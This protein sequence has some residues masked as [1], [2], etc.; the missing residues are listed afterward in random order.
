M[1]NRFI[2]F[3]IVVSLFSLLAISGCASSGS[4][5]KRVDIRDPITLAKD[6]VLVFGKIVLTRNEFPLSYPW[7]QSERTLQISEVGSTNRM[8]APTEKDGCFYWILPRGI[9]IIQEIPLP[10]SYVTGFTLLERSL[11]PYISFEILFPSHAFYLGTLRIDVTCD[12]DLCTLNRLEVTDEFNTMEWAIAVTYP[13][14]PSSGE[15]KLLKKIP[16]ELPIINS[17]KKFYHSIE[18]YFFPWFVLLMEWFN[19][20]IN[21]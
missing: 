10:C 3:C 18:T 8:R 17:E 14:F 11:R 19:L 9:Y 5:L 7:G 6:Q 1:R 16:G 20:P 4:R 21:R 2:A 13:D 15:K 12:K